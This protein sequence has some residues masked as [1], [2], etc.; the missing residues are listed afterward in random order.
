MVETADFLVLG[1]GVIGLNIA[2]ELAERHKGSRIVVLEKEQS[3]GAHASG[4]NSGVLHAGFYYTADS[5]KAK[6]TRDGNREMTSFCDT[7]GLR[8]NKCGKLVVARDES[9]LSGLETLLQR[10]RANGV[11]LHRITAKEAKE[12]EPRVKTCQ[13][14]LYSPTTSSV[15]PCEVMSALGKEANSNGVDLRFGEKYLGFK[16]GR[17]ITSRGAYACGYVVNAAGLFADRVAR[18]FGFSQGYYLLPFKGLYLYSDEPAGELSTHI[19]PV[20]NLAHPFLGSHFTVAVDGHIKIGPTAIPAFWREQYTWRD[21]FNLQE[22]VETAWRQV[23]LLFNAG[24]DFNRLAVEEL[25][26]YYRPYL[27]AQTTALAEGVRVGDYKTWGKHGIRAQLVR[28]DTKSLEMDFVLEGD[29]KSIHV[30]NAVS[31]AFTC[32]IP[33]SQYVVDRIADFVR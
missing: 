2:R 16:S 17:V 29:K 27:V 32:S 3:L 21:N 11:D 8:I 12:I 25:H 26:K 19:Y 5:L 33:F 24:F 30:L 1:A 18:D 15:D 7:R 13:Y 22:L 28:K 10:G 9:E 6:F 20:P 4:R 31:P 23:G 14:A